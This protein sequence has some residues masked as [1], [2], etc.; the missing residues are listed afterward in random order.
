[1]NSLNRSS[2]NPKISN[3]KKIRPVGAEFFHADRE[4]ER[5]RERERDTTKLIVV[6]RRFT[7]VPTNLLFLAHCKEI[8]MISSVGQ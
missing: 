6:I 7:N 8:L 2:T 4:R 1:L 5:E 3:F